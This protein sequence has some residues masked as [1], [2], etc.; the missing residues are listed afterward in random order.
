MILYAAFLAM[1]CGWVVAFVAMRS[2]AQARKTRI[3]FWRAK[4]SASFAVSEEV[5]ESEN[6]VFAGKLLIKNDIVI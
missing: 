3:N 5:V 1:T 6:V 2:T 4:H